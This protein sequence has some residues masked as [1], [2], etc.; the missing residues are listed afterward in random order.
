M[1]II[2]TPSGG[3]WDAFFGA[4]RDPAESEFSTF[5]L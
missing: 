1:M 2:M 5:K 3:R 4:G